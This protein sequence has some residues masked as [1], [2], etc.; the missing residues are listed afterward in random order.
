M[1]SLYDRFIV[2]PGSKPKLASV[3]PEPPGKFDADDRKEALKLLSANNRRIARLQTELYSENAQSLLIVLQ[4]M[5]AGGKDG[6]I[7]NV[8][9]AMNPQGC[10]VQSF[11]TPT[12]LSITFMP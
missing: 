9:Y 7:N 5:D 8:F 1:E 10:R 4:A 2:R 3:D 6:T 12:P 11:K